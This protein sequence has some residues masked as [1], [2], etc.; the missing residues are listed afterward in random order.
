MDGRNPF[1]GALELYLGGPVIKQ[2]VRELETQ[3]TGVIHRFKEQPLMC[4]AS[5]QPFEKMGCV[6]EECQ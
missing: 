1:E 4:F 5:E 2:C 6:R 3:L